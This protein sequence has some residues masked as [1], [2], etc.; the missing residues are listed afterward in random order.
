[1][2]YERRLSHYL[3]LLTVLF[4]KE[5][6]VRY[7]STTLGY[8]W[9]VLHPLAF[10]FVFFIAFKVVMRVQMED[11]GLFLITGLFPWQWFANSVGLSPL[12]FLSNASIIKK[13]RFPTNILPLTTVLQ[14]MVHFV[15]SL[16]VIVGFMLFYGKS[17]GIA[18]LYGIPILL[19]AQVLLT[20]GIALIISSLNLFFRDLE[21]LTGIALTLLFY[22]TPVVYSETMIPEKYR[23]LVYLNPVAPL[24]ISWRNLLLNG[25]LD[26]R[27]A[28]A[29]VVHGLLFFAAGTA[30]Y[31]KL[32]WKFGEAV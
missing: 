7:K 23:Y 26:P 24:M 1:M 10:A 25:G 4:L 21:R 9:S 6:K 15:L 12:I 17:P 8:L 16:P 18:W 11:Y 29:C 5:M 20:Y 30:V 27:L 28:A 13:I 31:N 32:S 3:D 22:F 19:A 2:S 14:D